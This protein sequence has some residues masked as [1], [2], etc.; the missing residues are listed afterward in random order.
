M[1]YASMTLFWCFHCSLWTYFTSFCSVS[2][3]DIKQVNVSLDVNW[4][5]LGECID[6]SEH[7]YH[8]MLHTCPVFLS[9]TLNMFAYWDITHIFL[10]AIF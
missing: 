6:N 3:I 10:V 4:R 1:K 9:K 8:N 7:S 5:R 2:I